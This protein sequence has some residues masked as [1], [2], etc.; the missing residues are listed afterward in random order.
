MPT[1]TS[2]RKQQLNQVLNDMDASNRY[3][4][5]RIKKKLNVRKWNEHIK[6]NNI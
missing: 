6:H 4:Y 5:G 2:K 1:Y 3:F